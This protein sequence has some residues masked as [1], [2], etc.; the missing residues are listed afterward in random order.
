MCIRDSAKRERVVQDGVEKANRRPTDRPDTPHSLFENWQ[1]LTKIREI[2]AH[3][4][5]EK[6]PFST[7]ICENRWNWGALLI[8]KLTRFDENL[9]KS[10]KLRRTPYLKT[11]DFRR[12]FVKIS[13]TKAHSLFENW[14]GLQLLTSCTWSHHRLSYPSLPW[15]WEAVDTSTFDQPTRTSLKIRN[16]PW[17]LTHSTW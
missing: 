3:S 16:L 14:Q 10:V 9:W 1:F 5:F 17:R 7:K 13:E 11:S 4:F 2:A 8:W 6:L 15:D 12:K